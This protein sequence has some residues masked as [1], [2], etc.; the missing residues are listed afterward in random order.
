MSKIVVG[1]DGSRRS[2]KALDWAAR[3]ATATGSTLTA[4]ACCEPLNPHVWVPHPAG[5]GD[6]LAPT[7][8]HLK[9]L[10]AAVQKRHP[11]LDVQ[12]E[13]VEGS[14]GQA[15]TEASRD[16]D[17]LVVGN[18]GLGPVSGLLVG[19]VGMHCVAHAACPVVVWREKTPEKAAVGR[20]KPSSSAAPRE[21]L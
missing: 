2:V 17:L 16:A 10:A 8:R 12:T 5:E 15:L 19:S 9:R 4:I 13:V 6:S 20:S 3:Y 14:P 11:E 7:R 18:R 1:V 21:G